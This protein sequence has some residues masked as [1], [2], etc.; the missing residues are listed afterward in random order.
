[1]GG[2]G[3][4]K[5]VSGSSTEKTRRCQGAPEPPRIPLDWVPATEKQML[6]PGREAV[7]S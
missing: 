5:K 3:V 2:G 4:E 6:R 1:M 7:Q